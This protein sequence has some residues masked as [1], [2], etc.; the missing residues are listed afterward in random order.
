MSVN[1]SK[2]HLY[3]IPEDD[4]D[5]Q[6]ANGFA[7][8]WDVDQRQIQVLPPAGGWPN[9]LGIFKT[10]YINALRRNTQTHLALLIDFDGQ[11]GDRYRRF[12]EEIPADIADRVYVLGPRDQPEDLKRELRM[13]LEEI[14]TALAH[15]CA[16][17]RIGNWGHDHLLHN[18]PV[19]SRLA[20][21]VRPFLFR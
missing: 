16:E 15:D 5:R 9:V 20:D 2:P 19:R 3:I 21:T 11:G 10:V 7:L 18:E 6:L 1:K 17:N 14:G 8:H 4:A 12:A 13:S